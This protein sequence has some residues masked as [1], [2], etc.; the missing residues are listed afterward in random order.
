MIIRSPLIRFTLIVTMLAG[1]TIL[2]GATA[3]DA[4]GGQIGGYRTGGGNYSIGK[5]VSPETVHGRSVEKW[6]STSKTSKK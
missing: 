5:K 3:A 1:G 2:L 4:R 6:G